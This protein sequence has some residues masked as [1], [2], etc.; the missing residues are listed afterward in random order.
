MKS[1]VYATLAALTLG[2]TLSAS[3]RDVVLPAGTLLQC[4]LNEPNFSTSTAA[5]GDPVLCHLR[6][7]TEFGQ[8]AFPRGSYLVGHLESSKEPGHFFGKGNMKLQFDRIGLPSGDLPLDAK[9]VATRGYQVDKEGDIRGKGHAKRDV[10]EWM[11]PPLWPWKV[12]MLPARGPRPALK[13]ESMLTLR[14]M[15]DVQVP[16]LAQRSSIEPGWHYFAQPRN[17]SFEQSQLRQ[18]TPQLAARDVATISNMEL[19]VA[20]QASYASLVTKAV[21][22]PAAVNA[23]SSPGMP[24]FVLT[25]GMALSVSSYGYQDGRITYTLTS[26]G[27]GVISTDDIDWSTTTRVNSQRGV[28]V[29]LHSK[30]PNQATPGM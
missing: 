30:R 3:A 11:L 14:L 29:T 2:L 22:V 13:G 15:D 24:V 19:T 9:L 5:V 16:Q 17:E 4:T 1:I 18:T 28:R 6:G 10:V 26:G 25:T 21:S 7:V 8:Q 20:P 23:G 27:S 12:I